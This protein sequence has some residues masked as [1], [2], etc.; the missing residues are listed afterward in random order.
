MAKKGKQ[1][2]QRQHPSHKGF[3]AEHLVTLLLASV[4]FGLHVRTLPAGLGFGDEGEMAAAAATFGLTHP[5]GFPGYLIPAWLWTKLFF[6]LEPVKA[7]HL[8]SAVSASLLMIATTRLFRA[9]APTTRAATVLA[10]LAA[11]ATMALPLVRDYAVAAEVYIWQWLWLV[12]FLEQFVRFRDGQRPDHWRNLWICWAVAV[13]IHPFSLFFGVIPALHVLLTRPNHILRLVRGMLP[14]ACLSLLYLVPV[15]AAQRDQAFIWPHGTGLKGWVDYFLA[16]E[17]RDRLVERGDV[18][19]LLHHQ[20]AAVL[21][22]V[23]GGGPGWLLAAAGVAAVV[24]LVRGV[25]PK[26][27][28]GL[29]ITLGVAFISILPLVSH[30]LANSLDRDS[31]FFALFLSAAWLISLGIIQFHKVKRFVEAPW[32]TVASVALSIAAVLWLHLDQ[33]VTHNRYASFLAESIRGDLPRDT[34]VLVKDDASFFS[35]KYEQDALDRRPDLIVLH[36]DLLHKHL[37][38]YRARHPELDLPEQ[39]PESLGAWPRLLVAAEGGKR[40]IVW[41]GDASAV[42]GIAGTHPIGS[43]W[44]LGGPKYRTDSF[45]DQYL[46]LPE[47]ER[48]A[49]DSDATARAILARIVRDLAL[50]SLRHGNPELAYAILDQWLELHPSDQQT[51]ALKGLLL[52]RDKKLE[53]AE[54]VMAPIREAGEPEEAAIHAQAVLLQARG[55]D[56]ERWNWLHRHLRTVRRSTQLAEDYVA[57]C[58]A[59]GKFDAALDYLDRHPKAAR[60]IP[61]RGDVLFHS[62]E[63]QA[64]IELLEGYQRQRPADARVLEKLILFHTL[65]GND[66]QQ[67]EWIQ[68]FGR[69]FPNHPAN[70]RY[71]ELIMQKALQ[72]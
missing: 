14:A 18:V 10:P 22:E 8:F 33:P 43:V 23:F 11:F 40:T 3:W 25:R 48:Q 13:T 72:N 47:R 12:L 2:K 44:W 34:L 16:A 64:A 50:F 66:Q 69:R 20:I 46:A 49:F 53:D 54:R 17:Y 31:Y 57:A 67:V 59:L 26:P 68:E 6:F 63:A 60:L 39:A 71:D 5:P 35:L 41:F 51:L 24:L 19:T 58:V 45:L 65:Q 38:H 62:G 61:L 37:D 36:L 55:L 52:I 9:S 70:R 21:P 1:P 4:L 27:A 28:R 32:G 30:G 15:L 7:L 42:A 56:Q 29:A